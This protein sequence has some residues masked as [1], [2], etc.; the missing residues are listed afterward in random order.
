M[1]LFILGATITQWTII[2]AMRKMMKNDLTELVVA[3][4][5][6]LAFLGMEI[7][8]TLMMS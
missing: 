8:N 7:K 5:T 2:T 4:L 1:S 3:M 6:N